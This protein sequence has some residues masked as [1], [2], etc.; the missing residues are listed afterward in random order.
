M[1]HVSTLGATIDHRVLD[2]QQ[3]GPLARAV[4]DAVELPWEIWDA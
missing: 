2:G 1:R 4:R 3:L